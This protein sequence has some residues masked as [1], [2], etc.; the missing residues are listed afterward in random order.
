MRLCAHYLL[1]EKRRGFA[2][3]SVTNFHVRNGACVHRI[4]WNADSSAKRMRE[5]YGLMV[6]YLYQLDAIEANNLAYVLQSHIASSD[7]VRALLK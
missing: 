3:N 7:Q 5:S 4:N 1:N 6:N 2:L